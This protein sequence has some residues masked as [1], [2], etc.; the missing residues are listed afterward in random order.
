MSH[1]VHQGLLL[2]VVTLLTIDAANKV[3]FNRTTQF[4]SAANTSG[5]PSSERITDTKLLVSR[6][7]Q[8][9]GPATLSLCGMIGAAQQPLAVRRTPAS[10]MQLL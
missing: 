6:R 1:P 7:H 4:T 8:C 3:T 2:I 5:H 9:Y 10:P